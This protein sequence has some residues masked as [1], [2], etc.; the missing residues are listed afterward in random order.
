[1]HVRG[2]AAAKRLKNT[3]LR[4]RHIKFRVVLALL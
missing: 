1:M 3:D 4:F 2:S